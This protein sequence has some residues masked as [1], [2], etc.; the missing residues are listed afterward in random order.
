MV[1][2]STV[3][4]TSP[5]DCAQEKLGEAWVLNSSLHYSI[6][7]VLQSVLTDRRHRPFRLHSNG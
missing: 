7:P 4:R 2:P 5:F 6:T 3:L 1:G